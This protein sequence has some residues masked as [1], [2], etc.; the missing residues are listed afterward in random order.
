MTQAQQHKKQL[1]EKLRSLNEINRKLIGCQTLEEVTTEALKQVRYHLKVQVAS[2]FLFNKDGYIQRVGIEGVDKDNNPI[3]GKK[4]LAD[5]KYLPGQSFSGKP[6]PPSD[7]ESTY[8]EPHYS[9]KLIEEYKDMI[10]GQKYRDKLGKLKSGISVPLNGLNRT[11][12]TLEVLNK[13][14]KNQL[15]DFDND[16]VYILMLVGTIISGIIAD[17]RRRDKLDLYREMTQMLIKLQS[18]KNNFVLQDVYQFVVNNLVGSQTAYKVAII[19][20][21]NKNKEFEITEQAKTEDISWIYRKQDSVKIGHNIVAEV[22]NTNNPLKIENI[23]KKF[24]RFFNKKWIKNNDLKSFI[25]I[26][27]SLG[28]E[29][30]GTLSVYVG[31][32]H[33]F[34][35][36][37]IYFLENIAFLTAGIVA[38]DRYK[39]QLKQTQLELEDERLELEHE[40]RKFTSISRSLSYNSVMKN[41]LHKY[42]NELIEF[43]EDLHKLSDKSSKSN[44]QK[45]RIIQDRVNWIKNRVQ[46]M[47]DAFQATNQNLDI[48]DINVIIREVVRLFTSIK[49]R[50][51][52]QENYDSTIP[53]IEIDGN[54]IKDVIYNLIDNAVDAINEKNKKDKYIK[55]ITNLVIIDDIQ[56]IQVIIEDSGTGIR[57]ELKEK[58]FEQGYTSHPESGGTGIGLFVSREI[59]SDYGGKLNFTSQVGNGTIFSMCLP[60][61]RYQL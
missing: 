53:L 14:Y 8:G 3:D 50:I 58:I 45:K 35:K 61:K 20:I 49:N 48:V 34:S 39:N 27:L 60:L 41:F 19:R 40:R 10:N 2:I 43:S 56:Y 4:W 11:F 31:Y 23:D 42:K 7:A 55:I 26:P 47:K 44:Q 46:E 9:N 17:F 6:V 1:Q 59:I 16:D 54:R 33:I 36:S 29:P 15:V 18:E 37:G 21:A 5:E 32:K 12:G 38:I 30:V 24:N 57:N 28:E 25:C 51:K 22:F 13:K 52:I